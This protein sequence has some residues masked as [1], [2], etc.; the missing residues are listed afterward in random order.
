MDRLI[1]REDELISSNKKKYIKIKEVF[2]LFLIALIDISFNLFLNLLI[3]NSFNSN[4]KSLTMIL[5]VSQIIFLGILSYFILNIQI[6][7]FHIVCFVITA[8]L[9]TLILIAERATDKTSDLTTSE[10][11]IQIVICVVAYCINSIQYVLH[12]YI[13]DKHY[14]SP[15]SVLGITGIMEIGIWLVIIGFGELFHNEK[16]TF[17]NAA[18]GWPNLTEEIHY[19]FCLIGAYFLGIL[20]NIIIILTNLFLTPPYNGIND[21]LNGIFITVLQMVIY[22]SYFTSL[23]ILILIF[24]FIICLIYS[25]VIVFNCCSIG[26]DTKKEIAKRGIKETKRM[27][28]LISSEIVN[29]NGPILLFPKP[30][31]KENN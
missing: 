9:L 10:Y 24:S 15:Y 4:Y 16:L 3:A 22:Q 11:I 31:H 20:T 17:S 8:L 23:T 14:Y 26:N 1:Q 7:R 2:I 12:K 21:T 5:R 6:Y 30:L 27:E 25:E 28:S 18:I 29:V 19:I 13:M